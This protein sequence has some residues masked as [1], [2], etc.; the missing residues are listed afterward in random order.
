MKRH[1]D[2]DD[3]R[4][5]RWQERRMLWKQLLALATVAA[6]VYARWRWLA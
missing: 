1:E 6:V 5:I 2:H 3:L 4:R